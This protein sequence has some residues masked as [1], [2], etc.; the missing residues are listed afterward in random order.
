[1]DPSPPGYS[2]V[3]RRS[4]QGVGIRGISFSLVRRPLLLVAYDLMRH[5]DGSLL[6]PRLRDGGVSIDACLRWLDHCF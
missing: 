5:A 3:P 1:V 6:A 2:V 4:C